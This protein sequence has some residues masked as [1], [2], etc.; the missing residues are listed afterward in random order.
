MDFVLSFC[1][2]SAHFQGVFR[3]KILHET[4]LL[5]VRVTRPAHQ[6]LLYF[7]TLTLLRDLFHIFSIHV[8]IWNCP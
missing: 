8:N 4:G 3:T 1:S 5:L 6:N 2:P 7:S